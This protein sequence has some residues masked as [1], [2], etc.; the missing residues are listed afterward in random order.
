[1]NDTN[2][3]FENP[4]N[5]I[6]PADLDSFLDDVGKY[7]RDHGR[8]TWAFR[9]ASAH[10]STDVGETIKE[11][12]QANLTVPNL[13]DL[14]QGVISK[15]GLELESPN[16][17]GDYDENETYSVGEVLLNLVDKDKFITFLKSIP[18]GQL[19][20]AE[21]KMLE[22]A[23]TKMSR[24]VLKEYDLNTADDRLLELLSGLKD[25]IAEYERLGLGVKVSEFKEYL[26][27]AKNGLKEYVL[28][29]KLG[30]FAPIGEGFNLSTYQK[31]ASPEVY[32]RLWNTNFFE[33][34]E[35]LKANP[36]AKDLYERF[37]KYGK[38]CIAFALKDESL[39]KTD[40]EYVKRLT[41]AILE[42]KERVDAI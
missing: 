13:L 35:K 31:D 12:V 7:D 36:K 22:M 40:S 1:M 39:K 25:I 26:N 19:T 32:L 4:D 9:A 30:A 17:A 33:V 3:I 14:H 27:Y 21:T 20:Q 41:P 34:L 16:K 38:D 28:A 5:I 10:S 8:G 24:Q 15:L 11:S 6:N 42:V 2:K 29:R 37:V 18:D 23:A